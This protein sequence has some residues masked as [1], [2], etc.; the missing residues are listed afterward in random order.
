MSNDEAWIRRMA[1]SLRS[2]IEH[3]QERPRHDG[4][5]TQAAIGAATDDRLSVGSEDPAAP[6]ARSVSRALGGIVLVASGMGFPLTQV[7]IA[8]L[9]RPGIVGVQAVTACLLV[10]AVALVATGTPGRLE[11]GPAA[12][13]LA[14][15]VAASVATVANA[16]L[17]TRAGREAAMARGWR[18]GKREI[19]RRVAMGTLFGLH[20]MRFRN[21][22]APGPAFAIRVVGRARPSLHEATDGRGG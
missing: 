22:L 21:D 18:V 2:T 12:L 9:G 17:F 1:A 4:G 10:R 16:T 19:V 7:A 8:R 6:S 20:T 13:L 15:T 14:E 5:A 3:Q 11:R